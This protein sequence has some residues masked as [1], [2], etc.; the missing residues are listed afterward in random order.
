MGLLSGVS[1]DNVF[2]TIDQQ[3]GLE[4]LANTALSQGIDH[5]QKKEYEQAAAAFERA[6]RL[7]P[8]SSYATDTSHYLASA[9]QKLEDPEKAIA[10]YRSAIVR[11]PTRDDSYVKLGNLFFALDR[12]AEAE[13]AYGQAVTIDP[14]SVNLYSLGE[15]QLANDHLPQAAETFGRVQY[16][17]PNNTNGYYGLGRVLAKQG[18]HDAALEQFQKTVALNPKFYDGY[19][20][21]G[22][23]YADMGQMDEAQRI[24]E[25]LQEVDEGLADTLSR[26][27]YKVDPPKLAF[28]SM[29]SSFSY[30]LQRGTS[31]AALDSYLV[32][33]NAARTFT[34][35]LQFDKEMDRASVE[36]RYNWQIGRSTSLPGFPAQY[37]FGQPLPASEIAL[38]RLPESIVYNA[39]TLTATVQFKITQNAA[40]NGTI[41]PQ[42]IE[43]RFSGKD[44]FGNRMDPESD[45]FTGFSG[46]H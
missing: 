41:D 24:F 1:A 11:N 28:A 44:I 2:A 29:T 33:A 10:A 7:A 34:M 31:L 13:Q 45:Q 12:K 39:D 37:N 4:T 3:Q 43:F 26:Y 22:Y 5:Y 38:P 42:H 20:E 8:A 27:M 18:E 14:S 36:N 35:V 6:L 30:T 25:Y 17:S 32:N 21:M 15:A 46:V 19:A 16:L 9:Y 40:G 23:T